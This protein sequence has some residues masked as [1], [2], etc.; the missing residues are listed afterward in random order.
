MP[1]LP[2]VET[3]CR[4]LKPNITGLRVKSVKISGKKLRIPIPK[5]ITRELNNKRIANVYRRAKYIMIEFKEDKDLLLVVHLG[6]SGRFIYHAQPLEKHNKH[7]HFIIKFD[8]NTE[9]ILND[10]RRFGLVTMLRRQEMDDFKFFQKLGLE[11]FSDEF[12]VAALKEILK[13]RSKN[14]KNTLMDSSLIVGIG[15]IYASEILFKTKIHPER[16]AASITDA[17]VK[18]IHKAILTILENAIKAGGSTLRDY[19]QADGKIGSFQ[20]DFNVYDRE[21]EACTKCKSKI[22]RIVQSNRSTFFCAKCQVKD[23]CHPG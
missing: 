8:D 16:A 3:I 21:G 2:E 23:P 13:N 10:P 6:M 9:L 18:K 4:G 17:E 7:D 12:D 22:I 20:F 14:I 11:P 15:N 5:L 19:T 1:E